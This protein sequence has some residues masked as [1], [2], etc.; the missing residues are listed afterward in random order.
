MPLDHIQSASPDSC[1]GLWKI[2]EDES[3]LQR[4]AQLKDTSPSVS[5]ARKRLEFYAARILIRELLNV[6][7]L[8]FLG[9]S[10]DIHGK[11]FLAGLPIHMSLSHSYP[12]VAAII[13][14]EKNVGIDLEQPTEKLL[15]IAPRILSYGE[16]ANAGNDIIKHCVYW[17]AKETL[18]KI[19][20]KKNLS[21][22]NNLLISPFAMQQSGHIIGRIVVNDTE[23]AIPLEYQVSESFVM[24]VSS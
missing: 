2:T 23:T 14:R 13:H 3:W 1:W 19:Y 24:V 11:P 6:W 5:N 12:Y 21:F 17:C 15:R 18:I 9:V 20:G 16:L 7:K 10:K 4:E 8:T 22:S